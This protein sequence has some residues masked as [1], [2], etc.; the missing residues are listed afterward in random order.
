[1]RLKESATVTVVLSCDVLSDELSIRV[2]STTI[3]AGL[4]FRKLHLGSFICLCHL[5]GVQ[6]H[7]KFARAGL[8]PNI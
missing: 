7:Q 4:T 6:L 1:M 5:N 3:A 8:V 2:L